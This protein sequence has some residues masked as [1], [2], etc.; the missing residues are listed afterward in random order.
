MPHPSEA[1][2]TCHTQLP[3]RPAPLSPSVHIWCTRWRA[4]G[5]MSAW[6]ASAASP[7]APSSAAT[8]SVSCAREVKSRRRGQKGKLALPPASCVRPYAHTTL[9]LCQAQTEV[10]LRPATAGNE[11]ARCWLPQGYRACTGSARRPYHEASPTAATGPGAAAGLWR[12]SY[13]SL[14]AGAGA[15]LPH[16][17][18]EAVHNAALPVRV[19]RLDP[20]RHVIHHA[21]GAGGLGHHLVG[22]QGV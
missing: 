14:A 6:Y 13:S 18:C 11:A 22:G 2:Q 7:R 15:C 10:A 20:P 3:P 8:V 1:A 5:S 9:R 21:F 12:G 19:L 17:A 16:L 4:A